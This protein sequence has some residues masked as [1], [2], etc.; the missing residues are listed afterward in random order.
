MPQPTDHY[1]EFGYYLHQVVALVDKRGEAMF[2]RELG[3]SLRQFTLL[4]L[5]DLGPEVPS[6]QLIADRLG[7]AKS[8]VS[9]QI[10]IARGNG[11][12]DV[13]V[14]AHSRRQHTLT[15]TPVG[16]HLLARAKALIENSELTG[17]GD[18]PD[19][20]IEATLRTLKAL[21]AK[22]LDPTTE[23]GVG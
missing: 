11:W 14:S 8:A 20:D 12:I 6:Q 13:T 22:L 3:I 18:L 2:R 23:P 19:A 10:D 1:S 16:R 21:H 9:R 4:R 15:L 5:F 7:I 17:F